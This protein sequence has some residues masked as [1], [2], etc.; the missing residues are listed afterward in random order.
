MA[1]AQDLEK[2]KKNA[3]EQVRQAEAQMRAQKDLLRKQIADYDRD[4]ANIQDLR[5]K[6]QDDLNRL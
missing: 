1:T 4:I 6:A 3:Q 2:M 5:R